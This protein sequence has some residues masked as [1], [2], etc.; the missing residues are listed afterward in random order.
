[1]EVRYTGNHGLKEWRQED[2]NEVN[3]FENGF[4]KE[5]YQAQKQSVHRSRMPDFLERLHQ[6]V[7]RRFR[8]CRACPARRPFPLIQTGLNYNSDTTVA[9]YLRQNR[10]GSVAG[11]MYNNAAA[12]GRLTAAGYP[13]NLFVVNPAVAGGGV[14]LLTN[15]GSST[16]NALQ[17]EVNRR[18][19]S[20]LLLQGSYVWA[21]SL[22]NGSQSSLMDFN[23]PTTPAQRRSGQSARRV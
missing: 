9:T 2:L 7:R 19:T 14:Y 18:M 11:L 22:V 15:G 3:L 6:C 1:M 20:G 8:Q 12:M 23:Q 5:F 16:Y 4:L 10:P 17:V 21:H 13:A